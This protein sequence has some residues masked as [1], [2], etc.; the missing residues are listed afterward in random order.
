MFWKSKLNFSCKPVH[1]GM[2]LPKHRQLLALLKHFA[3]QAEWC[4][5]WRTRVEVCAPSWSGTRRVRA[6]PGGPHAAQPRCFLGPL[7]GAEDAQHPESSSFYLN[8]SLVFAVASCKVF[9]KPSAC[10]GTCF[11]EREMLEIRSCGGTLLCLSPC[12]KL[13][14]TSA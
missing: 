4:G 1:E 7:A 2:L 3:E 14:L 8:C 12:Q 11:F 9:S 5:G 6:E 13:R 10:V